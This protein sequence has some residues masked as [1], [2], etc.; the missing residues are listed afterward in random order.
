MRAL[1]GLGNPGDR[2]REHRHNA[3]W[4]LLEVLVRRGRV[5]ERREL[6]RVDLARLELSGRGGRRQ[7]W[8]MRPQTYMNHSGPGVSQ[9]C[10]TLGLGP[11]EILVAYDDID[12]PLGKLRLRPGGG[13]GGHRG[14]RSVIRSLGT[15]RIPRLRLGV[16]GEEVRGDTADYVLSPFDRDERDPAAE[17]ME[18]AA[19]AVETV[20]RD[21]LA[22]AMN[23]FN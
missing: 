13:D 12:L 7:L 5:V 18:T 17:M 14:L 22:A 21:G 20:L 9:G 16:R 8:L 11:G 6:D 15:R 23:E 3:G 4:M 1:A 2:Y 10:E 19:D